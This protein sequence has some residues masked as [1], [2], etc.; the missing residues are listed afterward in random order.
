MRNNQKEW[1]KYIKKLTEHWFLWLTLCQW[2]N[3]FDLVHMLVRWNSFYFWYHKVSTEFEEFHWLI[4]SRI[5]V[6]SECD[7]QRTW[8][9]SL[10]SREDIEAIWYRKQEAMLK[11]ER[12]KQY[13]SSQ[14]VTL[15]TVEFYFTFAIDTVLSTQNSKANN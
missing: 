7:S 12:M 6:Q 15:I 3:S 11:R 2:F 13:S 14:R 4:H 8:D 9:C 1:R 5:L 10:L